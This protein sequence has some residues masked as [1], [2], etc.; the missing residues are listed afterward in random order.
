MA[1]TAD[2]ETAVRDLVGEDTVGKVSSA[3]MVRFLNVAQ[4]NL[5]VEGDI[6]LSEWT[7][8]TVAGQEEYSVPTDFLNVSS[9][10]IYDTTV[11]H[12]VKLKPITIHQRDP[13]K[14]QGYPCFYYVH[15]LNV[16]SV[17]SYTLGL[18]PIPS[19]SG[20]SNLELW[21]RQQPQTM[22]TGGTAPEILTPWQDYLVAYAAWCTYVR[23]GP[24]FRPYANDMWQIWQRG[25]EKA[26]AW[27]NPLMNDYPMEAADTA[28]YNY[29][30]GY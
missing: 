9:I 7:T 28:G 29:N 6:L 19:F 15:G 8:S 16:S 1:S 21:G 4:R 27:R 17:N 25:L 14:N 22:V 11:G 23:R 12:K 5:C 18:N 2:L 20:T 24:D 13:A 30:Y 26:K 3:Q 10:F